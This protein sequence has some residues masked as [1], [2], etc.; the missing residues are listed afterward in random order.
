MSNPYVLDLMESNES[1]SQLEPVSEL[2]ASVVEPEPTKEPPIAPV[3]Q[4]SVTVVSEPVVPVV[5][6]APV[7]EPEPEPEAAVVE[8]VVVE[9][10]TYKP[11]RYEV[12][13]RMEYAGAGSV[14]GKLPIAVKEALYEKV[15]TVAGTDVRNVSF[16]RML[17]AFIM[18]LLD[19][20]V[21]GIDETTLKLVQDI[22]HLD[23][24]HDMFTVLADEQQNQ[25]VELSRLRSQLNEVVRTLGVVEFG[26][27]FLVGN[28]VSPVPLTSP[29][30]TDIP[31]RAAP[32]IAA[33]KHL[34]Q[35]YNNV[36]RS[37][38]AAPFRTNK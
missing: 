9:H 5:E 3:E 19:V 10:P 27:S 32:F 8:R 15:K 29:R 2:V 20:S 24:V 1:N 31:L 23:L 21:P 12:T 4:A 14:P 38:K 33:R 34:R 28:S 7:V 30:P 16:E 18:A 35:E 25:S 17:T 37:D 13:S 6:A 11:E 26:T 36:Q 22:R